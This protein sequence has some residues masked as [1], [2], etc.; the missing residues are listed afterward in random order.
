MLSQTSMQNS[1]VHTSEKKTQLSQLI[2]TMIIH[3][4]EF[5]A[6]AYTRSLSFLI[7]FFF[8][9]LMCVCIRP[10]MCK[11]KAKVNVQIGFFPFCH[12]RQLLCWCCCS[13]YVQRNIYSFLFLFSFFFSS[14][15][16]HIQICMYFLCVCLG[17]AFV[18]RQNTKNI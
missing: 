15:L 16:V 14:S 2:I 4:T 10:W 5:A 6:H 3:T 13:C 12:F 1:V 8:D 7:F 9:T 17:C 11:I 18:K